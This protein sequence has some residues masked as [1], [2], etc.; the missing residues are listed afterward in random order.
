MTEM[1]KRINDLCKSRKITVSDMCRDLEIHRSTLSELSSGRSKSLSSQN[2]TKIANYFNVSASYIFGEQ[3]ETPTLTKKDERDIKNKI[4][5]I[6]DMMVSQKG[7]MFDGDPLSPEALE[8]IRS[9]MELG[10][11]AAKM[12]NKEKYNPNKN[13]KD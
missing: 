6:L 11:S 3:K 12:K 9:A 4:D 8:S 2:T 13:K 1:Y 5:E 7:L 10:M